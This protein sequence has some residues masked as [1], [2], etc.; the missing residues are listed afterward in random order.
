MKK[1]K[2]IIAILV[3]WLAS[4]TAS[5]QVAILDF[6]G[7]PPGAHYYKVEIN[8]DGTLVFTEVKQVVFL[9]PGPGPNPG[10]T[11]DLT[12]DAKLFRDS[13]LSVKNDTDLKG[14][15]T[16]LAEVYQTVSAK[17]KSGTL[18]GSD[19]ATVSKAEADKIL[20]ERKVE[21]NWKPF[22]DR[23]SER[24]AT[25]LQDGGGDTEL[26]KLCGDIATGLREAGK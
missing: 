16:K 10:P 6:T 25:V 5:A 18:T 13:A 3:L 9:K 12:D 2:T 20:Q 23:L 8:S 4:A 7:V 24:W 1:M 19:I 11:P 21:A 14:T 17:V 26:G 15:A 22:R